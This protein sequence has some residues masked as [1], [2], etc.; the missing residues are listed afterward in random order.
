MFKQTIKRDSFL[1]PVSRDHGLLLVLVQRLQ[2]AAQASKEDR[3]SLA[4]E[5]RNRLAELSIQYISDEEQSLALLNFDTTLAEE[6]SQEHKKIRD[7]LEA[8]SR[9]SDEELETE[10]FIEL[11]SLIEDHVRWD[12]K[13]VFPYIQREITD[14]E[15][16][17]LEERSAN[18]EAG[19]S[20]P[21]QR[22]HHSIT[23]KKDNGEAQTCSCADSL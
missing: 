10:E 21:I 19:R 7:S 4:S 17:I 2:K 15:R 23:L 16:Q 1:K 20:R 3:I 12:E 11:A 5:I 9:L 8:F 13:A 22:L 6:I 18:L 14:C